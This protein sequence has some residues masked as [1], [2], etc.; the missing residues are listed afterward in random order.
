MR[1][2]GYRIGLLLAVSSLIAGLYI[3]FKIPP[4]ILFDKV[5]LYGKEN[6][7][8]TLNSNQKMRLVAFW[9][10]WC[11]DCHQNMPAISNYFSKYTNVEL[12]A[13][14]NEPFEKQELHEDNLGSWLF[15][16]IISTTERPIQ[17]LQDLGVNSFPMY[18]LLDPAGK[19]VW[20]HA[21]SIKPD[22]IRHLINKNSPH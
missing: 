6:K 3:H 7:L 4:D 14:S 18:F 12:I 22:E 1:L 9:Q 16:R 11:R 17:E 20:S 21:G 2:Y 10:T 15:L 5:K 19:T 13:I 8:V